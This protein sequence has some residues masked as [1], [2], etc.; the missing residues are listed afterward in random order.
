MLIIGYEKRH[1]SAINGLRAYSF[2]DILAGL[3]YIY[4]LEVGKEYEVS[5]VD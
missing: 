2:S 1:G 3:H 4:I 5:A